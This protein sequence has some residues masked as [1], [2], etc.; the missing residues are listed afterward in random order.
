M[1]GRLLVDLA[2]LLPEVVL[3][4]GLAFAPIVAVFLIYQIWL[5]HL[6][7]KRVISMLTGIL[8]SF[9][10][11]V[12]FFLGLEI[13]FFEVGVYLGNMLGALEYNII[14]IPIGVLVGFSIVIAEPAVHSLANQVDEITGGAIQ[15]KAIYGSMCIGVAISVGLAALRAL[16]AMNLWWFVLPGYLIALVLSRYAPPVFTAIAFDSGGV[17]S[18]PMTST[19]VLSFIMGAANTV[20]A[21]TGVIGNIGDSFGVVALVAMMPLITLQILGIIYKRKTRIADMLQEHALEDLSLDWDEA[22]EDN[23]DDQ[24]RAI[25]ATEDAAETVDNGKNDTYTPRSDHALLTED[26]E[27]AP[28]EQIHEED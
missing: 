10:G 11:L 4:V 14:L 2:H 12:L 13:G 19:F 28:S 22:L 9:L 23:L 21:K 1:I 5:L 6:P 17:A 3:E 27:H 26:L 20:G 16:Y 15:K 18:G 25:T 24:Y 7:K 8:F